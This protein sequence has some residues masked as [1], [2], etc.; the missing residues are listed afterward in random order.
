MKGRKEEVSYFILL[1]HFV[2]F[3]MTCEIW[4]EEDLMMYV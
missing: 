2:N 1:C 4:K 3:V